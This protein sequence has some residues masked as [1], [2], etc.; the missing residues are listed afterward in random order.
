MQYTEQ[1]I[2]RFRQ[3]I[4]TWYKKNKRDLPWRRTKDPYHIM[5]SE[6]M[7]QQTQVGRVIPY[8]ERFLEYYPSIYIVAKAKKA[9]L[10]ALWSGL[11]Y[12]RRALQ[13]LEAA[14]RIVEQHDGC[15]P[16]SY[17]ELILLPGFGDYMAS[18]IPAFAYNR[19]ATVVDAN[20]RRVFILELALDPGISP[21]ALKEIAAQ[22]V[23]AG[24]SRVWHNAL[25]D[26]GAAL[27]REAKRR[28]PPL[29]KQSAFHGSFRQLRGKV[30]K[31]MLT[32]K[33]VPESALEER[34][35]DER[36]GA[37]LSGLAEEGFIKIRNKMVTI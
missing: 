28:V 32:A 31:F 23:P 12:N 9:D 3:K 11:G 1:E 21:K 15:V 18:A 27:P 35:Q 2:K 33:K 7:L 4:L 10:L 13:L 14:K 25:M 36:L 30:L 20:I 26:Y 34:F 6:F 8:F 5:V 24:K 19:K 17:E 16:A 22:F 29:T 37:V